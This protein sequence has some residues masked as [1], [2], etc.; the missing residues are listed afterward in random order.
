MAT[1]SDSLVAESL[2]ACFIDISA[3]KTIW[4]AYSGGL[5]STVLL[6]AAVTNNLHNI[7]AVHID[8]Q[9]HADS[10]I[11]SQHCADQCKQLNI[12]LDIV[13]VDVRPFMHLGAEGAAREARY[14]AFAEKLSANDVLFT[15][16][17]A[18]DQIETV[19]LQLFRGAGA[20]GLAGC[21]RKRKLGA[22]ILMR[23]F[24]YVRRTAIKDYAQRYKLNWLDDPSN[25]SLQFDRNYLRHK[26]LP[27]LHSRW[28]GLQETITRTANLQG[29]QAV[30]LSELGRLDLGEAKNKLPCEQLAK[31]SDV[32][33]RNLLR[34]WI[35]QNGFSVPTAQVMQRIIEDVLPSADD[36]EP[37][38]AWQDCEIR[39]YRNELYI[40]TTLPPHDATQRFEWNVNETLDIPSLQL[41]LTPNALD[42][43]GVRLN[44]INYLQVGFRIGGE[45]MRPRGRGC[46]KELK[47]LFQEAG[48]VPWL[49]NR[50]P[51]LFDNDRLIFV[52]GYWIAEG[53]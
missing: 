15:A 2:Q 16:H 14:Q 8:H 11:W 38:I 47:T 45:V 42:Q 24:L 34:E 13:C 21:A 28:S 20:H 33:A 18:D 1:V 51:L 9:L 22:A 46:Q 39:K 41:T 19:L 12:E 3:N 44:N 7:R 52:W 27:L 49:R 6:H 4:V 30:L 40:Q 17:H 5:D 36:R 43:F 37:Y 25:E 32:R 29:E 50:I 31:L 10:N 23:P 26:I 53:Y 35:R 48:V